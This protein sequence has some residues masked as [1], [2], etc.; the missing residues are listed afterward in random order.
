ME[1]SSSEVQKTLQTSQMDP[2]MRAPSR[3]SKAPGSQLLPQH[4]WPVSLNQGQTDRQTDRDGQTQN[5]RRPGSHLAVVDL[6]S[7]ALH[8]SSLFLHTASVW[9]SDQS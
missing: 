2:S 4:S 1:H 3:T 6:C 5:T 9:P 7:S 8:E